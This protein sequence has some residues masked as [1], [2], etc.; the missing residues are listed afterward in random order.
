MNMTRKAHFLIGRLIYCT[1]FPVLKIFFSVS[2]NTRAYGVLEHDDK[3]LLVKNWIGSGNWSFPGGGGHNGE[4]FEDTLKR[5]IHEEIGLNIDKKQVKLLFKG[6][7]TRK[8]GTKK[9][10]IFHVKQND[11]PSLLINK[12]EIIDSKWVAKKDLPK[13]DS[14]SDD[15]QRVAQ[16][17]K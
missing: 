12:L 7:K 14:K 16:L 8:L 3:V 2:N 4:S 1:F 6:T 9:Y 11:K 5:E 10:V 17:I 15:F 13:F